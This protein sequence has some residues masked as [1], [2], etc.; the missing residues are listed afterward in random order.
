MAQEVEKVKS[1][2]ACLDS[3]DRATV[4]KFIEEFEKKTY[5]EQKTLNESFE[6]SVRNKS[7]GPTSSVGCPCCGK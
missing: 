5:L 4:R 6:K 7:L 2:Y 1:G 3:T